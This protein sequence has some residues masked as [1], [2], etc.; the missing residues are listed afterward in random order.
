MVH[1]DVAFGVLPSFRLRSCVR[2]GAKRSFLFA[3]CDGLDC[4]RRR[5]HACKNACQCAILDF[6]DWIINH[7]GVVLLRNQRFFSIDVTLTDKLSSL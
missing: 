3:G 5:A 4:S 7:R 6:A 1:P 2:S